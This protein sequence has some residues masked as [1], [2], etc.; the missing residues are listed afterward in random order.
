MLLTADDLA[1]RLGKTGDYWLRQARARKVP[2]RRIG[3][4][5]LWAPADVDAILAD[6]YQEPVDPLR[7]VVSKRRTK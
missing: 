1:G 6:A 2:H 4:S 5:I 7:S 3:A